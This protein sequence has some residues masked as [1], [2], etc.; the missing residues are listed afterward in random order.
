MDHIKKRRKYI[1]HYIN[2][3]KRVKEEESKNK[4]AS[5]QLIHLAIKM[6]E[7]RKQHF[8]QNSCLKQ[9]LIKWFNRCFQSCR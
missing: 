8:L 7:D 3:E 5:L 1:N 4:S 2:A 6:N 9:V